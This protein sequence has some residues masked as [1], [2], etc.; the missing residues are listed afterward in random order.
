MKT[1]G[2]KEIAMWQDTV[3]QIHKKALRTFRNLRHRGID[4]WF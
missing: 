3:V 1:L 4:F 2:Y